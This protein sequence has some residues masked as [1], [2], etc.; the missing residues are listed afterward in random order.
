[1][2]GVAPP[3]FLFAMRSLTLPLVLL[4]VLPGAAGAQGFLGFGDPIS[5]ADMLYF[6]GEPRHSLD[7]LFDRLEADS[8]DYDALWRAAR[9]AVVIGIHE[10]VHTD[11]NAWLDP[12]LMW[13]RRA[14]E[15]RPGAVDGLYWRGVAAGRRA[16]NAGPGYAVD[17]AQR[18]YDDAHAILA[19]DS[20]HGG[21][22]NM[23]GKLNYEVMSMSAIKRLVAR[24]F[25]DRPSLDDT[26]WEQAEYHLAKAA[27]VEPEFVL[28]HFDLAQLYRK[29][30]RRDEAI[31]HYREVIALT[32]V[33]PTDRRLQEQARAALDE[34]GVEPEPPGP[35]PGSPDFGGAP[36]MELG[37]VGAVVTELV[38]SGG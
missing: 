18:V 5:D 4:T 33:H 25:M 28:F 26:S 35:T 38:R 37:M 24:T 13:A 20:L 17:L 30:G 8:L 21:A 22:H 11:Q 27:E 1:M 6:A 34:W 19:Q 29:R 16:M 9:A 7:R 15:T 14:A 23:L 12:A 31:R 32:A 10:D 36:A 3:S 2:A